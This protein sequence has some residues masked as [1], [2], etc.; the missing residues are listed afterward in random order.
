M[1]G[2]NEMDDRGSPEDSS[3]PKIKLDDLQLF[4][5]ILNQNEKILSIQ[6]KL[7]FTQEDNQE[8]ESLGNTLNLFMEN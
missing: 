5:N 4:Q 8:V 1:H 6:T 2:A 3:P 7:N